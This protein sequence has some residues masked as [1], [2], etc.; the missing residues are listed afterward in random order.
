MTPAPRDI[1]AWAECLYDAEAVRFAIDRVA[2]RIG[3]DLADAR[4]VVVCVM[5]GGLPFTAA[6]LARFAFPLEVDHVHA[7]RYRQAA[8]GEH[9]RGGELSVRAAPAHALEGR[10]VLLVDDVLD[11]G[12]T[13]ERLKAL[14]EERG[15]SSIRT[16]VLVDK[17]VAG[18]SFG[19]D[20][21]AL[22]APDRYLVG[23]GMD[24]HGWY[25]NLQAIYA[26]KDAPEGPG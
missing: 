7:K 21:A 9:P 10:N 8:P 20:Y 5:N 26:L 11:E 19:A 4:P 6:L 1:D 22:S 3:L 2:V 25:R 16:A 12:A 14:V 13:L 15:A 24:Y 18:R 17:A 23:W